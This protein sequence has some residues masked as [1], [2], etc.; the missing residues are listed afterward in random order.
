MS[1]EPLDTSFAWYAVQTLT[2]QEGKVK[3]YIERFSQTEELQ[4]YIHQVLVPTQVVVEIKN[5]RKISRVRKF[6]P[7]YVFVQMRLYDAHKK[8]FHKVW[9]FIS[10]VEGVVGF[11]GGEFPV[12]LKPAEMTRILDQIR[13]S[14]GREV[15]KSHYEL[16]QEVRVT[17]GPFVNLTGRV[18]AVDLERGRLK[19]AVS[20][21]GRFT[22]VE[23]EFWQVEKQ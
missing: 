5:G 9:H 2:N 4:G 21:F 6:Y 7:G 23:L 11:P 1:N 13:Q 15:H 16:G 20:I 8:L 18:E 22:P 3:A 19:V 14:E 17:Q 12:A 10:E